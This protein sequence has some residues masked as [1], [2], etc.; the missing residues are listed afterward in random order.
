MSKVS[1][2]GPRP[3]TAIACFNVCSTDM[4]EN[5]PGHNFCG[6]PRHISERNSSWWLCCKAKFL[7]KALGTVLDKCLVLCVSKSLCAGVAGIFRS[8]STLIRTNRNCHFVS[9]ISRLKCL[10]LHFISDRNNSQSKQQ[11]Y[12][13]L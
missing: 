1:D 4:S 11:V 6:K 3:R 10:A 13:R 8:L 5:F 9:Y 7:N 2:Q 12:R